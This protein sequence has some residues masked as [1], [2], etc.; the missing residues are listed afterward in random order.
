MKTEGEASHIFINRKLIGIIWIAGLIL[1][2]AVMAFAGPAMFPSLETR[3]KGARWKSLWVGFAVLIGGPIAIVLLGATLLGLPLALI[4]G[5]IYAVALTIG[6][7]ASAYQP[8]EKGAI[9]RVS[10][11]GET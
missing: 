1:V 4:L 9:D 7:F 2:A 10:L 6:Y 5:A 11:D 8:V 3:M